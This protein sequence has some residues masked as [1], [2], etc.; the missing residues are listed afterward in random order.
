MH[1][2][3]VCALCVLFANQAFLSARFV[4]IDD[5]YEYDSMNWRKIRAPSSLIFDGRAA[6]GWV[7]SVVGRFTTHFVLSEEGQGSSSEKAKED[8]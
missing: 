7:R 2:F 4:M 5:L 8:I 6:G 1:V 3:W